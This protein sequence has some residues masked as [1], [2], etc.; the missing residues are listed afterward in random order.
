MDGDLAA[1]GLGSGA[2]GDRLTLSSGGAVAG[3]ARVPG[4]GLVSP[5][6]GLRDVLSPGAVGIGP[7]TLAWSGEGLVR[8]EPS[9]VAGSLGSDPQAGTGLLAVGGAPGTRDDAR[10]RL[11]WQQA[12]TLRDRPEALGAMLALSGSDFRRRVLETLL[13]TRPGEV[14][15]YAR[16]AAAVGRPEAV[17]AVAGAVGS[18]RLA[19]LVPCHR[20]VRSDGSLG[21]YRWGTALKAAL[22]GIDVPGTDVP[23]ID[24]PGP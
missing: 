5:P 1:G 3:E 16:L 21:G 2:G 24:M 12:C 9:G 18:N 19:W 22:L 13:G 11:L 17:R 4:W 10:A 15:T 23:G 14:W 8:V 7:W 6:E 20:V